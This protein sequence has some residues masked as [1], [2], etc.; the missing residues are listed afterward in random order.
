[1]SVEIKEH[2][3][4]LGKTYTSMYLPDRAFMKELK[5]LDERL[6]CK[7]RYDLGRFVITWGMPYGEDAEMFVVKDDAGGFRHPDK[8]DI[9]MLCEGDIHATDIKERVQRT[10]KYMAKHRELEEK[11]EASE[12]R[13]MTKDGRIQL[14]N[15]YKRQFNL[16][17]TN[18]EFRRITHKPK[19][20]TVDELQNCL[21]K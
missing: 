13:D 17:K 19:G 11:R 3:K 20:K 8:R 5:R 14:V 18:V 10:E 7:Y 15:A 6:G 9:Y 16:G 4:R 2:D 1:M 21:A 12:I